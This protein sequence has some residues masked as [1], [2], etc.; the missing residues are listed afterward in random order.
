MI[1]GLETMHNRQ[2][3]HR[4]GKCKNIFLH[5]VKHID[6]QPII[7][8][9]WGDLDFCGDDTPEEAM[10]CGTLMTRAPEV[11]SEKP[12]AVRPTDMWSLGCIL[13]DLWCPSFQLPWAS[14][15]E[16]KEQKKIELKRAEEAH[17]KKKEQLTIDAKEMQGKILSQQA[18]IKAGKLTQVDDKLVEDKR[19]LDLEIVRVIFNSGYL[20]ET[21]PQLHAEIKKITPRRIEAKQNILG[22]LQPYLDPNNPLHLIIKHCFTVEPKERID[23][24]AVRRLYEE[25][26]IDQYP[27]L[28][29]RFGIH[30]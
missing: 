4:D 24:K 27:A 5:R 9:V 30:H 14:K 11:N 1:L 10:R 20:S 3:A 16:E 13:L 26:L 22:K 29:Q 15:V 19:K 7:E 12:Y 23:I 28:A 8:A 2:V 25:Y 17:E 18:Q 6:E 21:I